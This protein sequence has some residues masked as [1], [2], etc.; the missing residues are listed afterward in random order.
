MHSSVVAAMYLPTLNQE[1]KMRDWPTMRRFI[2]TATS[3]MVRPARRTITHAHYFD[4]AEAPLP[5]VQADDDAAHVLW[6][7]IEQLAG[8]EEA[9][10]EDHFHMLDHFFGLTGMDG[11]LLP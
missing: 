10:F 11:L 7:P 2:D 6:V 3:V 5:N 1:L 8:M 4:L 9:F